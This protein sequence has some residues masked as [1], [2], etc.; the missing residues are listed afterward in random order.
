MNEH[1]PRAFERQN[2]F[3]VGFGR[4]PLLQPDSMTEVIGNPRGRGPMRV[5]VE[6]QTYCSVSN[7]R[8]G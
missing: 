5:T 6:N 7:A 2:P 3:E 4:G 8:T 1:L